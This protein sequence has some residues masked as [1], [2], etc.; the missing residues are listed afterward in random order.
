MNDQQV[1]L[2][3][4]NVKH[5]YIETTIFYLVSDIE[6]Q[7]SMNLKKAIKNKS[8]SIN[9]N[10]I[11]CVDSELYISLHGLHYFFENC[12]K[13]HNYKDN[14]EFID[15]VM[16]LE[17]PMCNGNA[18]TLELARYEFNTKGLLKLQRMMNDLIIQDVKKE[19]C[20]DC[21]WMEKMFTCFKDKHIERLRKARKL[22]E[23]AIA[24]S[25]VMIHRRTSQSCNNCNKQYCK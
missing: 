11:I 16:D 7:T 12:R 15:Y 6:K 2:E 13:T 18:H 1:N 21:F 19:D 9:L 5:I 3:I 8:L 20:E 4:S 23:E 22:I 25:R 14:Q 24:I 17:I 10:E